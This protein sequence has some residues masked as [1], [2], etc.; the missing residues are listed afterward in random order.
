MFDTSTILQQLLRA[1][2]RYKGRVAIIKDEQGQTASYKRLIVGSFALSKKLTIVTSNNL[3]GC[4]LPNSVS[5]LFVFFA[6]LFAHKAPAILN[7]T[8]PLQVLVSCCRNADLDVV[9]TSRLFVEKA[10]LQTIIEQIEG[11]GIRVVYL[12]DVGQQI[13]RWTKLTALIQYMTNRLPVNKSSPED[14]A[15]V[16]FTSGSEAEPKAVAL[17]HRNILANCAQILSVF[18]IAKDEV[19]FSALPHFHSFGLTVGV[20]LPILH[21]IRGLI[22]LSPLRH[23]ENLILINSEKPTLMLST[24]S[25]LSQMLR[26]A[27]KADLSSLRGIVAGAERLKERTRRAYEEGFGIPLYEGYGATELSPVIAVNVPNSTKP[28]TVGRLLPLIEHRI[29][30]L[31]GSDEGGLLYVRGPNLMKSYLHDLKAGNNSFQDGWYDTG[32]IVTMDNEGYLVLKDRKKRFIKISGEMIS[33]GFI[34]EEIGRL[35][36]EHR[37]AAIAFELEDKGKPAIFVYSEYK[38]LSAD[39]IRRHFAHGGIR[40]IYL[41]KNVTHTAELP[42]LRTGKVD[43]RAL[44][45][46]INT[47]LEAIYA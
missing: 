4:L 29:E 32:D 3:V 6:S 37:H 1:K 18:P 22:G 45:A 44:Q 35:S 42:L 14:V 13:S 39:H 17:T 5:A 38:S 26:V 43:Y 27:S 16:L 23:R 47:S 40:N 9:I 28:G 15:A 36:P 12:E 11:E 41:P 31:E 34:E 46:H 21:G 20:M 8:L 30:P 24:D 10:G 2:H 19:I 33:L 7:Y 25:F